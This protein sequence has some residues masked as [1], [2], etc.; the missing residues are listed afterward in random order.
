MANFGISEAELFGVDPWDWEDEASDEFGFSFKKLGRR[1]KKLSRGAK[2]L[3]RNPLVKVAA[4][5]LAFVVPPVGI[6][7]AVGAAVGQATAIAKTANK[8]VAAGRSMSPR[9]RRAAKKVVRTTRALA[10]RGDVSAKR[11]LKAIRMAA[12]AAQQGKTLQARGAR[13]PRR[14]VPTAKVVCKCPSSGRPAAY[15]VYADG[16]HRR[17]S[18]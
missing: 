11:G 16:T 15:H 13:A 14:R 6:A 12:R 5:S 9:K 7:G 18:A 4:G 1:F 10:L 17:L 2:K 3:M 8:I